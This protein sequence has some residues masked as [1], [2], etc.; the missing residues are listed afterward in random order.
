MIKKT[1]GKGI[2]C[3]NTTVS[4]SPFQCDPDAAKAIVD[5]LPPPCE[6]TITQQMWMVVPMPEK[7]EI[8]PEYKLILLHLR[9]L[10][11]NLFR[12]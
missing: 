11:K 10:E 9:L 7:V 5:A 2:S 4:E 3:M 1:D 12:Y 6:S 8:S